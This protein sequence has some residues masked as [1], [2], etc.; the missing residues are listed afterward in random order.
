MRHFNSM[1]GVVSS[2]RMGINLSMSV[3][4]DQAL[5]KEIQRLP[6]TENT[7]VLDDTQLSISAGQG[8]PPSE[9][10]DLQP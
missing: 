10:Q 9:L 1:C 4:M 5:V 7:S 3:V 8:G 6:T 2:L